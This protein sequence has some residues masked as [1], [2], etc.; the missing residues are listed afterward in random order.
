MGYY[1]QYVNYNNDKIAYNPEWN[2]FSLQDAA[3]INNVPNQPDLQNIL[4]SRAN[5]NDGEVPIWG[6]IKSIGSLASKYAGPLA[7]AGGGI[8]G[9]IAAW[10]QADEERKAIKKRNENINKNIAGLKNDRTGIVNRGTG[11]S[12][13]LMNN[14]AMNNNPNKDQ[15]YMGMYASNVESTNRASDNIGNQITNLQSQI[16]R[17]PNKDNRWTAALSGAFGGGMGTYGML[18]NVKAKNQADQYSQY[19]T[20]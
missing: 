1:D 17:V 5:T 19:Y 2:D 20:G 12:V 10:N 16:M 4:D 15:G 8:I 11:V 6:T 13:N 3:A 9:G 18:N 14:Y 7:I